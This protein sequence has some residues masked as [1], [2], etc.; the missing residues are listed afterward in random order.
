MENSVTKACLQK[1]IVHSQFPP[2]YEAE[3]IQDLGVVRNKNRDVR[4]DTRLGT[5]L[6]TSK[7]EVHLKLCGRGI[8]RKRGRG[9]WQ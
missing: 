2:G 5:I 9:V 7:L 8:E 1:M 4:D 3:P 6:P